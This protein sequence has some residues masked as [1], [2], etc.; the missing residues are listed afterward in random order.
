MGQLVPNGQQL[1]MPRG[2]RKTK[3]GGTWALYVNEFLNT[4]WMVWQVPAGL[5]VM[6]LPGKRSV[7]LNLSQLAGFV[8]QQRARS[9]CEKGSD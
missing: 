2:T 4:S 5:Q 3:D 9:C 7:S 1:M 6:V 8:S